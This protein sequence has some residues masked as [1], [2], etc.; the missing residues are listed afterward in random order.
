MYHILYNHEEILF[1]ETEKKIED[2]IT[3]EAEAEVTRGNHGR[4][5]GGTC[6]EFSYYYLDH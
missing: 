1:C 4:I 3:G 5:A 6:N 2:V